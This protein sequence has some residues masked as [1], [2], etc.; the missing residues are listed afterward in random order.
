MTRKTTQSASHSKL[1]S[2]PVNGS[3]VHIALVAL[4][5]T[6]RL[7]VLFTALM[8]LQ[9]TKRS[10]SLP[11]I[12][13]RMLNLP[14]HWMWP[15]Q[16]HVF[17]TH[18]SSPLLARSCL[19]LCIYYNHGHVHI[20]LVYNAPN[21]CCCFLIPLIVWCVFKIQRIFAACLMDVLA[22]CTLFYSWCWA[23]QLLDLTHRYLQNVP[24]KW[25]SLIHWIDL[26]WGWHEIKQ[27]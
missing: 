15:L 17:Y 6:S 9:F 18:F 24:L 19:I 2:L 25:G 1:L 8:T 4:D 23:K 11:R 21:Q 10:L 16:T 26:K 7:I 27:G 12:S 20:M 5:A 13:S 14:C 3:H 22:T